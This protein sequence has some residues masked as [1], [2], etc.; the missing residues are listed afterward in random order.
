MSK[1]IA[2]ESSLSNVSEYLS[3][4]GYDVVEFQHNQDI[5]QSINNAEA[6]ITSGM[7]ENLVG[8]HN[9][10]TPAPVIKASGLTPEQIESMLDQRLS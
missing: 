4:K 10:I 3:K 7:D 2:V 5:Q 6:I 8:M 1:K 9:I